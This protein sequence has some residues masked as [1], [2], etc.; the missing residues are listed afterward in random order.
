MGNKE[1]N[2]KNQFL[3]V[4]STIIKSMVVLVIM[5]VIMFYL[6]KLGSKIYLYHSIDYDGFKCSKDVCWHDTFLTNIKWID[7]FYGSIGI[8]IFIFINCFSFLFYNYMIKKFKNCKIVVSKILFI[9]FSCLVNFS[10]SLSYRIDV[11]PW[12]VTPWFKNNILNILNKIII[13]RG[14]KLWPIIFL[15]IYIGEYLYHK[16]KKLK[17]S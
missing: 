6:S 12:F 17:D 4:V 8:I 2:Y 3:G 13:L 10:M 1:K 14:L 9:I 5:G 7:S 15:S 16:K 11:T